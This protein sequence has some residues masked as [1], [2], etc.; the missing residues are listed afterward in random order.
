[1]TDGIVEHISSLTEGGPEA[2]AGVQDPNPTEGTFGGE[3]QMLDQPLKVDDKPVTDEGFAHE[4]HLQEKVVE[5][6]DEGTETLETLRAELDR[7]KG[8]SNGRLNELAQSRVKMREFS[9]NMEQMREMFVSLSQQQADQ[10]AEKLRLQELD[11]EAALYGEDVVNNPEA[12]YIRDMVAANREQLEEYQ[13]EQEHYR[14]NLNEQRRE[15]LAQQ[16]YNNRMMETLRVQEEEFAKVHEDY[17]DAY[18]YAVDKRVD[19]W[20]RRGY[21]DDQAMNMVK[22]EQ[23]HLLTEQLPRGGNV[24]QEVYNMAKDWGW[25]SA[26][27]PNQNPTRSPLAERAN[28]QADIERIRAGVGSPGSGSMVSTG[29]GGGTGAREMTREQFFATVPASKRTEL[30]MNRP[31]VFENLGRHGRVIVD[32]D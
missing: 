23:Q 19:M 10:E 27:A 5:T 29:G 6:A 3:D 28:T 9:E 4:Q 22:E 2:P 1:M 24:A 18:K 25:Q 14:Q 30:F 16:E 31:E 8:E 32:W 21:T 11:E 17:G 20:K 12:R 15:F 26:G 7:V 13:Q